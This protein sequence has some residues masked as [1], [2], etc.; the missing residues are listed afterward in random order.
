MPWRALGMTLACIAGSALAGD[1]VEELSEINKRD[2]AYCV[3]QAREMMWIRVMHNN[4]RITAD[5]DV[6]LQLAQKE[7]GDCLAVLPTLLPLPSEGGSIESWLADMRDL[8]ILKAGTAP[9]TEKPDAP[10]SATLDD[11]TWRAQCRA[12][13]T[14]WEEETG[15]VVRRGNPERVRCPCGGV[16]TCGE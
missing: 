15:T 3:L 10:V 2:A 6:V 13:Y 12:E 7:Y 11:E 14:T 1:R 8:L 16:V 5:T 9:A 4:E